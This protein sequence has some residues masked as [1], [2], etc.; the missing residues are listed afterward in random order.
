MKKLIIALS[1]IAFGVVA[2]AASVSWSASGV[3]ASET[4]GTDVTKYM[5]YLID[6]ANYSAADVTADNLSAVIGSALDSANPMATGFVNAPNRTIDSWASSSS[7]N[8]A[9]FAGRG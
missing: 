5:A 6:C 2:N 8:C 7:H 9:A 1:A 4:G 3:T